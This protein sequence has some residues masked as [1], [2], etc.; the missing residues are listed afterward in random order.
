MDRH[1]AR[2]RFQLICRGRY[3]IVKTINGRYHFP[4]YFVVHASAVSPCDGTFFFENPTSLKPTLSSW[5][6]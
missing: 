2:R 6:K 4:S 3:H 1:S 5:V